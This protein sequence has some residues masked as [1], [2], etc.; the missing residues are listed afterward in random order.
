MGKFSKVQLLEGTVG[1]D[2]VFLMRLS[3]NTCRLAVLFGEL[4]FLVLVILHEQCGSLIVSKYRL[5]YD[6]GAVMKVELAC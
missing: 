6:L 5:I 3:E 4:S 2:F 1:M